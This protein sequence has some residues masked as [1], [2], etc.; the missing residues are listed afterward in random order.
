MSKKSTQSDKAWLSDFFKNDPEKSQA[1]LSRATGLAQSVISKIKNG[2][3]AVTRIEGDKID[4]FF[5]E[6]GFINEVQ[7][8]EERLYLRQLDVRAQGGAGA[9]VESYGDDVI[10]KW[11]IPEH[12]LRARTMTKSENIVVAQIE[13]D[14]MSPKFNPGD[15][16][17]VDISQR[18]KNPTPPGYFFVWEG[19]GLVIK[20]VETIPNSEPAMIRLKSLNPDYTDS[21]IPYEDGTIQGRVLF[22][23]NKV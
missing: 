18:A 15:F 10:G 17:F 21:E 3:R 7:D 14:S 11:L 16:V 6:E 19:T 4:R 13:G 8:E 9:M 20:L 12:V 1:D 23:I 5:H 22:V 2:E